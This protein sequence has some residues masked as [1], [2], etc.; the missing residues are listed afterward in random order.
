[1]TFWISALAEAPLAIALSRIRPSTTVCGQNPRTAVAH[2]RRGGGMGGQLC[3]WRAG[4]DGD[5][6][7]RERVRDWSGVGARGKQRV[8]AKLRELERNHQQNDR[9]REVLTFLVDFSCAPAVTRPRSRSCARR[10]CETDWGGMATAC[11]P[12]ARDNA[13][14]RRADAASGPHAAAGHRARSLSWSK[15]CPADIPSEHATLGCS[16]PTSRWPSTP[17][18]VPGVRAGSRAAAPGDPRVVL[19]AAAVQE[20]LGHFEQA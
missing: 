5:S 9:D 1:M 14:R 3:A 10:W 7:R 12:A 13:D 19:R 6:E 4:T 2:A 20:R 18:S 16:W 17:I 15:S 11:G 8:E